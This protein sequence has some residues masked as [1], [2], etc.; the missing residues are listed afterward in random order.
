MSLLTTSR[1]SRMPAIVASSKEPRA[2]FWGAFVRLRLSTV[3]LSAPADL[4]FRKTIA[5]QTSATTNIKLP[6][7]NRALY[8]GTT[9]AKAVK[10]IHAAISKDCRLG[11]EK[12][13][14]I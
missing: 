2:K 5:A 12:V 11:T 14:S 4:R 9:S 1:P 13:Q 6:R 8:E 10:M 7:I 3:E